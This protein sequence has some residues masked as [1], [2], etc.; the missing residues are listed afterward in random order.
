MVPSGSVEAALRRD[1]EHRTESRRFVQRLT[2]REQEIVFLVAEGLSNR[3][4]S[5]INLTEGDQIHLH[6]IYES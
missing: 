3:R 4:R 6:N 2:E 5:S 1:T